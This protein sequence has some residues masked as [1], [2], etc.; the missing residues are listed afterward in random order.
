MQESS[1]TGGSESRHGLPPSPPLLPPDPRAVDG[2]VRADMLDAGYEIRE[3]YRVL[4]KA[5]LNVVGEVLRGQGEFIE[6]EHYPTDDVLDRDTHSQ[7]YYHAHRGARDEHGHFHTFIRTGELPERIPPFDYPQASE[8]WPHEGD[9]VAHLVG[10]AM[11]DWGYPTGLFA[12]N[13]WVTGET[14]YPAE[15]VID[16]LPCFAIDHAYPS[17]PVNRWITAMLRLFRPHIQTL[18]RHRDETVAAWQAAAPEQDVFED[19]RLEITGYIP[20]SV[21]AWLAQLAGS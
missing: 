5:G 8:S 3:C 7:Y 15:S 6:M 16:L 11:D 14:W 18:L 13:R 9:A 19:R 20:I 2:R 21:D 12:T 1:S 4:E 10:I 17:W